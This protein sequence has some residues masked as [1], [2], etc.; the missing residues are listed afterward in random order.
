MLINTK[1]D[2]EN[3]FIN[4]DSYCNRKKELNDLQNRIIEFK[5][6]AKKIQS[7]FDFTIPDYIID[8]IIENE[9]KKEYINLHYLINL[10]VINGRISKDNGKIIKQKYY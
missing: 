5:E 7:C 10:A 1:I 6:K 8:E 9:E 4:L 3:S 2:V